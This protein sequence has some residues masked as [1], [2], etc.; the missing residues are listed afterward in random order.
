[1]KNPEP[2]ESQKKVNPSKTARKNKGQ[3]EASVVDRPDSQSFEKAINNV[4]IRALVCIE[5]KTEYNFFF[6]LL[7]II[8]SQRA[9][10]RR[11]HC[12][13]YSHHQHHRHHRE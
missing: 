10:S 1:M 9:I 12:Y 4:R 2:L 8:I 11:H 13:Y 7:F 5:K 6:F 3:G